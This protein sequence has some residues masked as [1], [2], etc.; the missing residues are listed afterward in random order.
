MAKATINQESALTRR[1]RVRPGNVIMRDGERYGPGSNIDL[2][3]QTFQ[4]VRRQVELIAS[5][6]DAPPADPEPEPDPLPES[7]DGATAASLRAMTRDD[8][9]EIAAEA[10]VRNAASLLKD[11]LVDALV[12]LLPEDDR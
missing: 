12:A 4:A 8:L 1:C 7:L 9:R 6:P 3:E 5:A 2:D 10:G 11:A